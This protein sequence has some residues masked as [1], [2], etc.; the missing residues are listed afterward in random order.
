MVFD[1]NQHQISRESAAG[2]ISDEPPASPANE[3]EFVP[4][5]PEPVRGP[6]STDAHLRGLRVCGLWIRVYRWSFGGRVIPCL[7]R[8][9]L[10]TLLMICYAAHDVCYGDH[11]VRYGAS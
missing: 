10:M 5:G 2:H 9:L 11:G 4:D 6:H 7:A 3:D 8:P 1:A